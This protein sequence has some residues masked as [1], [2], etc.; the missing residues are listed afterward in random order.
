MTKPTSKP[1]DMD[2]VQLLAEAAWARKAI[3]IVAFDVRK[4]IFYTDVMMVCTGTSDRHVRAVSKALEAAALEAGLAAPATEGRTY[5][6]WILLDF[7]TV[8]VHVFHEF[9]REM[10]DLER[11]F[12]DAPRLPLELK[13]DPT[14]HEDWDDD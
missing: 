13:A 10:Y 14:D 5:G 6:R 4:T 12:G 11:L 7:G 3:D 1:V 9:L 8:T 2:L